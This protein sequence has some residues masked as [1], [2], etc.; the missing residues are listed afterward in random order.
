[1]HLLQVTFVD[2]SPG[3]EALIT[4]LSGDKFKANDTGVYTL[5]SDG[6][7]LATSATFYIYSKAIGTGK[8]V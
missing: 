8:R 7:E 3:K 4:T 5:S 6:S 1:L 2:V